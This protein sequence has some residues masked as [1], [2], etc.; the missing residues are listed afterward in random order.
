MEYLEN[1]KS[2]GPITGNTYNKLNTLAI[3][4][5]IL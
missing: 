1:I 5:P 3:E 4:N 2:A